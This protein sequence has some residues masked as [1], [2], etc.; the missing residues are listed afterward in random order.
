MIDI[1]DDQTNVC[2]TPQPKIKMNL[3]TGYD[4]LM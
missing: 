3:L 1:Y 4:V 2:I